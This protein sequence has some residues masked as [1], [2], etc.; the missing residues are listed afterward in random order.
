MRWLVI[1]TFVLGTESA[2]AAE[3]VSFTVAWEEPYLSVQ[4][5]NTP[6]HEVL[7]EIARQTRIN[8]RGIESLWEPVT[9]DLEKTSLYDGLRKILDRKNYVIVSTHRSQGQ[10]PPL[11]LLLLGQPSSVPLP[12]ANTPEAG[13]GPEGE[14]ALSAAE[15]LSRLQALVKEHPPNLRENLIA[16]IKDAEP[17]IRELAYQQLDMLGDS[18]T[19]DILHR[20]T[21]SADVDI[22]RTAITSF[23]DLYKSS[24]PSDVLETLAEAASDDNI[25]VRVTAFER[26][27][28][29]EN[30]L[31]AIEG[32]L[33]DP[34]PEVRIAAIEAMAT[35]GEEAARRAARSLLQDDDEQV[36]YRA[37]N[38]FSALRN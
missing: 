32:K 31:T 17:L 12:S 24:H 8:A 37:S 10:P 22:R 2:R 26:L 4:A 33:A 18:E 28:Q 29:M 16:A 19:L 36:R 20:D 3:G 35:Q 7:G 14:K 11:I 38:V 1:A 13:Q 9:I 6:L 21:Q 25:D 27:L 34:N 30:G 23:V 15:R 5:K